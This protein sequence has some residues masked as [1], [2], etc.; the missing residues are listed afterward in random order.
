MNAPNT[1][2]D[3]RDL[4]QFYGTTPAVRGVSF[5]LERGAIAC[6]LGPSGCGKTT[7][8]RCI[9]GFEPVASGEIHL[10]GQCVSMPGKQLPP[11]RRR[12]GMVFQDF[13]LFPHLDVERNVG[14]GL[15]NLSA[16]QRAERIRE[17][18]QTVGLG[19]QERKYPH[20][21]SGG[22][23][24]RVALARALAP[25]P[26][27]L[28]LDEPFS[29]LDV[30]LREQLGQ[31]VR[32][33]IHRL[34]ATALLVTHDQQE[35][36][37]MADEIGVM[38]DGRIE[39]WGSAYELYHRPA[40]RFVADFVGQGCFIPGILRAVDQV[41]I[42]LGVLRG[43]MP[44]GIAAAASSADASVEVLLRPDDVEIDDGSPSRAR[45]TKKTFRG[46]DTLYTLELAS[47]H[48]LVAAV[49]SHHDYAVGTQVG[50]RLDVDHVVAFPAN[51][52]SLA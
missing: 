28:L 16:P 3:L 15:R 20:Q 23:Q 51:R 14:F 37:A 36:F 22:Q 18:V 8:L 11:E 38:R 9:A 13:A 44:I 43:R 12:I 26:E 19:G 42:E 17:C 4:H 7:V 27:L 6:L 1:L 24:Q 5:T 31:E 47:G 50:I 34:G 45:I 33:I 10:A 39:Q 40:N 49:P 2:L 32:D 25:R 21:L 48:S 52:T 30:D 29:S 46:A 35:A 41:E